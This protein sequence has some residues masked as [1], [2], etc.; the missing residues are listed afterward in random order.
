M[1]LDGNPPFEMLLLL[2]YFMSFGIKMPETAC[3]KGQL[4]FTKLNTNSS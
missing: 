3:L 2:A 4:F 1:S